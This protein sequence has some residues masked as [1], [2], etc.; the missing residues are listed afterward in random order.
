MK[1]EGYEIVSYQ[2]EFKEQIIN[3]QT[4]LWGDDLDRNLEYF[5]W[6]Y[7]NNPYNSHPIIYLALH[8]GAVVGMRGFIGG[9]WQL[10]IPSK[11]A[12]WLLL[13]DS[14]THPDHRRKGIFAN[15]TNAAVKELENSEWAYILNLSSGPLSTSNNI[16]LGW[17]SIG[18]N[19]IAAYSVPPSNATPSRA[20]RFARKL[21][22]IYPL[23]KLSKDLIKNVSSKPAESLSPFTNFDNRSA[24]H[25]YKNVM[26]SKFP[27]PQQMADL[28]RGNP[29]DGRIR[30]V[31][32]ETYYNWRYSNPRSEYRFLYR[33]SS[34]LEGFLVLRASSYPSSM[35][36]KVVDWEV[37]SSEMLGELIQFALELGELNSLSV[38]A[39]TLL[40]FERQLLTNIGFRIIEE[41]V[42]G[43]KTFPRPSVLIKAIQVDPELTNCVVNDQTIVDVNKWDLRSIYSDGY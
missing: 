20:R 10:G 28:V 37:S 17:D 5:V 12:P 32:D 30:H 39:T 7:E 40:P 2:P 18:P 43:G 19:F 33:Q 31:R 3:L 22:I 13:S 42:G 24:L 14:V 27:H 11:F 36:V 26:I 34:S 23:Y 29:Y 6:K 8:D 1:F 35:D 38:W 21:P 4:H 9:I 16:K 15:I 41:P 25:K